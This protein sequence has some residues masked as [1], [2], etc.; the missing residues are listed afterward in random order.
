MLNQPVR[1]VE[2][3][4]GGGDSRCDFFEFDVFAGEGGVFKLVATTTQRTEA[5]QLP[6]LL[7]GNTGTIGREAIS[8]MNRSS[9]APL[10]AHRSAVITVGL[11]GR[12]SRC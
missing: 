1:G 8:S 2:E 5:S 12:P 10:R 3:V 6:P 9:P 11:T 7:G 4:L